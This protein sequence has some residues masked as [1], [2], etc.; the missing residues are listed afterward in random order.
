M[1]PGRSQVVSLFPRA[2]ANASY[3]SYVIVA[4]EKH[5]YAGSEHGIFEFKLNVQ[6]RLQSPLIELC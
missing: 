6:D 5:R 4:D 1:E 3:S 2:S